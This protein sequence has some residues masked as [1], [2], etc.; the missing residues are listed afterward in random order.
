MDQIRD[1]ANLKPAPASMLDRFSGAGGERLTLDVLVKSSL[2]AGDRELAAKLAA[3]GDVLGFSAGDSLI[4]EGANDSDLYML[5]AGTA[6]VLVKGVPI[7]QRSAG[8][9]IGEIAAI[10]PTQVR[11]AAAI[12]E[13]EVVALRVP[14]PALAQIATEHPALWRALAV[15]LATRLVQRNALVRPA[16][17]RPRVFVICSVEA[18]SIAEHVA[19]GLTHADMEVTLWT[20]GV[21]RASEYPLESLE[22]AVSETD[23]AIV[24]LHPDDEITSRKVTSMSPRDNVTFEL[25]MS[26]G[27]LK[28]DRM[29]I[30]EPASG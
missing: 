30:L 19:A 16:N 1:G 12:A 8:D 17:D 28:R 4:S 25:G 13:N 9:H 6:C 22:R 21:F 23:F 24:V 5:L 26:V 7:N 18:L 11:S 15:E 3:A 20:E 2:V 14:E 27:A 29:I 10:D